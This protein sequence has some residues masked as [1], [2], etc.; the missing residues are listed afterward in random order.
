M[1]YA[2]AFEQT[3]A[4]DDWSRLAPY[5]TEDVTYQVSGLPA[6]CTIHGRD[7]M[8][9][10]MKKSIDGFDRKMTKRK[11]V[12]SAPPVE[13]GDTVSFQGYVTYQRPGT[14][15]IDLHATLV[16]EFDGDK[17]CRMHDTFALDGAAIQWLVK[18]ASDLD[19]SYL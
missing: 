6:A 8:F 9:A 19:G 3:F 18:H 5:F 12:P 15:P 13:N 7:A 16:A 11:I 2:A 10:G 14:P 4:D 17:I 1:A